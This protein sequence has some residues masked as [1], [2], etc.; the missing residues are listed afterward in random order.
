MNAWRRWPITQG[1]HQISTACNLLPATC[2]AIQEQQQR[3]RPDSL[4]CTVSL[5]GCTTCLLPAQPTSNNSI[6]L[7]CNTHHDR[8]RAG[9]RQP[10]HSTAR[11][12]SH[13]RYRNKATQRN[14]QHIWQPCTLHDA[15]STQLHSTRDSRHPQSDPWALKRLPLMKAAAVA[16]PLPRSTWSTTMHASITEHQEAEPD[17][18]KGS[19]SLSK[20]RQRKGTLKIL[21]SHLPRT[22]SSSSKQSCPAAALA[23]RLWHSN[24]PT[25][26]CTTAKCISHAATTTVMHSDAD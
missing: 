22:Q 8:D 20:M 6:Q 1:Q 4:L 15:S 18:S 9:T 24:D 17:H 7:Y 23:A 16:S 5:P 12:R 11:T 25:R 10:T 2:W 21:Q 14:S 19:A 13:I 26:T 3:S